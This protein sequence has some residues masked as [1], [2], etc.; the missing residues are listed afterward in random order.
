MGLR[1]QRREEEEEE[2]EEDEEDESRSFR[3][4]GSRYLYNTSLILTYRGVR[5]R[6]LLQGTHRDV[7]CC[8]DNYPAQSYGR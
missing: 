3:K 4:C 1:S 5:R 6:R 7:L 2:E 8:I